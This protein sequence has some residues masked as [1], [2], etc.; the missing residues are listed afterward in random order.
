MKND[1]KLKASVVIPN[2]NSEKYIIGTLESLNNQ[3]FKDFEVIVV[4]DGSTDKS[5]KLIKDFYSKFSLIVIKQKNSGPASAR[6]L[7]AKN[8]KTNIIIFLDSDCV[9]Y[10]DFIEE[11][12]KPFKNKEIVGVHGMYVTKNKNS[13]IARY[14]GYEM[15]FRQ[16]KMKKAER[17]DHM[18]THAAAYRKKDFG[19]G[20]SIGFR[21]ADME[22]IEFSYRL[23]KEGKKMI[24]CES[25]KIKHPHPESF[26][27]FV[28]QQFSRGYWRV[29]GHIMH[30]DK[31]INDSYL[32][33][34]IAIQG[35]LS[36]LFFA[37]IIIYFANI[38]FFRQINLVWLP[39]VF[40]LIL[41]VSNIN[42]GLYCWK[43]EKKMLFLA[44]IMAIIRS[45]SAT[46]GFIFGFIDF[47]IFALR[48]KK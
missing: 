24:F 30:P 36:L 16:E 27:R 32:G 20:F 38:I 2:Y 14:I 23:A 44:P 6:N 47:K 37:S 48:D 8:S 40:L 33:R 21:K 22:D 19:K 41:Y 34:S 1:K 5:A 17:I 3:T 29:L 13:F 39:L 12:I 9:P 7:G 42:L 4:D 43:Y 45:I 10:P 28:K 11:M 31:L 18:A 15:S 46:L 26:I 25:A 35:G